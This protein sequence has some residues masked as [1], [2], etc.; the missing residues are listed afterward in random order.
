M[1]QQKEKYRKP[2]VHI[3]PTLKKT[4]FLR[5]IAMLQRTSHEMF[6]PEKLKFV[7]VEVGGRRIIV[8][9]RANHQVLLGYLIK[10]IKGPA[11]LR[12]K[13]AEVGDEQLR[14]IGITPFSGNFYEEHGTLDMYFGDK[15]LIRRDL[16]FAINRHLGRK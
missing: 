14:R 11:I 12:D 6:H 5:P 7:G 4:R 9:G 8:L 1:A 2:E 3:H 10:K 15:P 16:L 13:F